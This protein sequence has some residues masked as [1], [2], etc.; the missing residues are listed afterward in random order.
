[1]T[2]PLLIRGP[3][4]ILE[5]AREVLTDDTRWTNLL[6]A[7]NAQRVTEYLDVLGNPA[8]LFL[9]PT[10]AQPV[11]HAVEFGPMDEDDVRA[12]QA[13]PAIRL[14]LV[15]S[16]HVYGV[17]A[18]IAKVEH[19]LEVRTMV[20]VT[21]MPNAAASAIGLSSGAGTKWSM[22]NA[23]VQ[24]EALALAARYLLEQGLT[25]TALG[26]YNVLYRGTSAKG[27][28]TVGDATFYRVVMSF[29]VHQRVRSGRYEYPL[30]T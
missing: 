17:N 14:D 16:Q 5:R 27:P 25:S 11:D 28:V 2:L 19:T 21:S 26:V 3:M 22:S 15:D 13:F 23:V 6:A 9:G 8:F 12:P 10:L 7:Y 18:G 20:K 24:N 30:T 4:D 1:M 29:A